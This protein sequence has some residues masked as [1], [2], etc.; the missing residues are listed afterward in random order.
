M[1]RLLLAAAATSCLAAAQPAQPPPPWSPTKRVSFTPL[2]LERAL[3]AFQTLCLDT[4]PD[5]DALDRAAAGSDLGFT[6]VPGTLRG[7]RTWTSRHGDLNFVE[8]QYWPGAP[9]LPQCNFDLAISGDQT[10]EGLIRAIE[11][12]LAGEA[13]RS[14]LPVATRWR[15]GRMGLGYRRVLVYLAPFEDRRLLTLQVVREPTGWPFRDQ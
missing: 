15:L 6:R 3:A 12:R 13:E 4:F 14:D 1:A 11:E 5:A 2:P 7:R 10:S 9:T 8:Q